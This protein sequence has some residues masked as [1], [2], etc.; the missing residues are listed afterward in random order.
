LRN[1]EPLV[2]EKKF[3]EGRVVAHLTKLSSSDTPLGRWSN[4]SVNRAFPVLANELISYLG[5]NRRSDPLLAVGDDLMVRVAEGDYEPTFVFSLPAESTSAANSPKS[6]PRTRPEVPIDATP[7]QNELVAKLKDVAASGIYDVQLRS[8][9]GGVERR[10]Y[11]VNL[12]AEEGDLALVDRPELGKQLAGVDYQL[13]DAADMA[14][15][16]QQ[17]AGFQ[18]TDA[19]L[20]VIIVLLLV[21]QLLAYLASYHVRPLRGATR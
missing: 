16:A 2:I 18:M 7:I 15:S 6:A 17:L 5:T 9:A 3:G 12:P 13:H 10:A 11:A 20:A 8:V 1:N 4:W 19:L 21:E 14:L